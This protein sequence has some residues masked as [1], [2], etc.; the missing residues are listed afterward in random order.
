MTL[1]NHQAELA[2][3]YLI[4]LAKERRLSPLTCE[5]YARDI[6]ALLNLAQETPLDRLQIHHVRR[7]AAQLHGEGFSGRSL[8]R[9][10]SA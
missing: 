1:G 2:S 6:R 5:S 8:A 4:H 10:L 9:M 7:F 3:A